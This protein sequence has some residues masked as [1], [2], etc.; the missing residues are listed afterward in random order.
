MHQ[1]ALNT[2]LEGNSTRIAGAAS[3]SQ[4]QVH[5]SLVIETPEV[6]ISTV[7]LDGWSNSCLKKLLDHPNNLAIILVVRK[8][9]LL[10]FY[11]GLAFS[12]LGDSDNFLACSDSL[13][14]EGKDLGSDMCPIRISSL[15][16]SD[17]V[18]AVENRSDSVYIH[19]LGGEW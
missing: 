2:I 10:G 1:H 14:N 8:T 9:I 6:N 13:R 5:V 17:K 3:A 7:F 16:D 12:A 4:T 15:C 19:K 11:S 18:G